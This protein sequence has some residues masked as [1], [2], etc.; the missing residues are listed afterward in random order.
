[1]QA[2]PYS[3]RSL[4]KPYVTHVRLCSVRSGEQDNFG[5]TFKPAGRDWCNHPLAVC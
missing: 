1:M 4:I 2:A 5:D 3:D